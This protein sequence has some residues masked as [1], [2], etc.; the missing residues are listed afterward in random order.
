VSVTNALGTVS[1]YPAT[2]AV[3]AAPPSA[4]RLRNASTRALI[5]DGNEP[6]IPGLV[7]TGTGNARFLLRAIGPALSGFG[8]TG[9]IPNPQLAVKRLVGSSYVD[10]S[11][12]NDWG[13]NANVTELTTA[14]A[15]AGA[16]PLSA[17]SLDS[18]LLLDLPPG[19]Y[20]VVANDTASR[21]GVAMVEVYDLTAATASARLANISTRAF[22]GAGADVLIPG[23]VVSHE[24]ARTVLVRAIGPTLGSFGVGDVL[25]DPQ[26]TIFQR[27]PDGTDLP[28]LSNNDWSAASDATNTARVAAEV[29]AFALSAGSKDAALVATLSPGAYTV[30][31]TGVGSTTGNALVEVYVVP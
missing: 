25:A 27:Q 17:G 3:N 24:G 11:S 14:T 1:T 31:V 28:V 18:A 12:N 13:T 30:Q 5:R 4:A 8:V 23:F 20:T 6:L 2:V 7:V 21:S 9:V 10:F 16:F 22:V 15:A 29:G 26:L 19:Q